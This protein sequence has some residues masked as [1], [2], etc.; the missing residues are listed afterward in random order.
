M[1]SFRI[2]AIRTIDGLEAYGKMIVYYSEH[3]G[4]IFRFILH[5][6]AYHKSEDAVILTTANNKSTNEFLSEMDLSLLGIRIITFDEKSAEGGDVSKPY[7]SRV[8]EFFDNLLKEHNIDLH[9]CSEIHCGYHI[10]PLFCYYLIC[11][12]LKFTVWSLDNIIATSPKT[13]VNK[14]GESNPVIL[15]YTNDC[16]GHIIW[17]KSDHPDISKANEWFDISEAI[18]YLDKKCKKQL[19]SAYKM[20]FDFSDK[21]T[22]VLVMCNDVPRH[23]LSKY[24]FITLHKLYLYY[25]G[26]SNDKLIVKPHPNYNISDEDLK[27]FFPKAVIMPG[28]IPFELL[29]LV[30]D[31][32][33]N[34]LLST[35]GTIQSFLTNRSISIE[36]PLLTLWIEYITQIYIVCNI[37]RKFGY[38]I[39][40]DYLDSDLSGLVKRFC[41]V[42]YPGVIASAP[43]KK[44]AILVRSRSYLELEFIEKKSNPCCIIDLNPCYDQMYEH[45][46]NNSVNAHYYNISLKGELVRNYLLLIKEFGHHD[47]YSISMRSTFPHSHIR[48]VYVD[49]MKYLSNSD[50]TNV[51]FNLQIKNLVELSKFGL[52]RLLIE[53]IILSMCKLNRKLFESVIFEQIHIS[54]LTNVCI[55]EL[56]IEI[57]NILTRF[58]NPET[59][60]V[61]G[62]L[63]SSYPQKDG[64]DLALIWLNKAFL[65]RAK[66]SEIILFDY[67]KSK[68]IEPP[69]ELMERLTILSNKGNAHAKK[70][71]QK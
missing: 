54:D 51:Y 30:S 28:H 43:T 10:K 60:K 36:R 62:M 8:Q 15:D 22:N 32:K 39:N 27:S 5:K 6:A 48:L 9:I 42:V 16:V 45:Y 26:I 11:N 18:R 50:L 57:L 23:D 2:E 56:Y 49:L 38:N 46:I 59:Y 1:G 25:F 58:E 17:C 64:S 40:L 68:G 31:L 52:N 21:S 33:V 4:Y 35:S 67:M 66:N 44:D 47:D 14:S 13:F 12:S 71:I 20:N 3:Y 34:M 69:M 70:R 24:D 61:L 41:N 65:N 7:D 55:V 63:Y 19:I 29:N 53:S 37:S